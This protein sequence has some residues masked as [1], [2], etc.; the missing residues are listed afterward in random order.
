MAGA[1][2]VLRVSGTAKKKMNPFT[3]F[4]TLPTA[5]CDAPPRPKGGRPWRPG[6]VGARARRNRQK[7]WG[8]WVA[9]SPNLAA[10][11]HVELFGASCDVEAVR[12]PTEAPG[13]PPAGGLYAASRGLRPRQLSTPTNGLH[14]T[15]GCPKV[16]EPDVC[17]TIWKVMPR[18][19]ADAAVGVVVA[20]RRRVPAHTAASTGAHLYA[21]AHR[22]HQ[23]DPATPLPSSRRHPAPHLGLRG[24][25]RAVH[26][27]LHP[28]AC[29]PPARA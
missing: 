20:R 25:S 19:A 24:P 11:R 7:R 10:P 27:A 26:R 15:I 14:S 3:R 12:G 13:A 28:C 23:G 6:S 2:E 21:R 9:P 4:H 22:G 16:R 8:S 17:R 1:P 29:A 18:R 5:C